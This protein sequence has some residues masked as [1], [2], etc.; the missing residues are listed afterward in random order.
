M[1][2]T[3][4]EDFERRLTQ[5]LENS[6]TVMEAISQITN[7]DDAEMCVRAVLMV[8]TTRLGLRVHVDAALQ[9]FYDLLDDTPEGRKQWTECLSHFIFNM[10]E[11][12]QH[13]VDAEV[14][15]TLGTWI[16]KFGIILFGGMVDC[17][18]NA[19]DHACWRSIIIKK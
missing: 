4:F 9:K 10:Y 3:V 11:D 2:K 14:V 8:S 12:R 19:L 15:K 1:A 13:G 16:K 17:D 18:G 7:L 5:L 6:D